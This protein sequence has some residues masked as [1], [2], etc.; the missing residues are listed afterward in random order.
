MRDTF[1]IVVACD[2]NRGIGK[3]QSLPWRL[4]GDLNYFKELTIHTDEKAHARGLKNA[5]IMGRATWESIPQKFRPLSQRYNLVLTR[6]R[7]YPLPEGVFQARSLDEALDF[8]A[9]GPVDRT[10]I[11]GGAQVYEEAFMHERIGLLY[12]TEVRARFD[13]DR[14]FPDFKDYF[15]LI[16]CSEIMNENGIE[17]CFKVFSPNSFEEL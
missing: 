6:Q 15:S 10:F 9:R 5:C 13:C 3:D 12:L 2:L 17:Y 11:I 14:N 16:S 8:L 7:D 4:K 1:D